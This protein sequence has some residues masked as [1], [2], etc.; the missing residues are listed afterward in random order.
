MSELYNQIVSQ[1]GSLENLI[2][3]I[4]GFRGYVDKAARRTADRMVRD[5]IADALSQRIAR[6]TQIETRL[7]DNGGLSYM[8]KTSRVK[9]K[10]QT[11]RDRVKAAAP[12]YS[13]WGEAQKVDSDALERIYSF[14]EALIRYA[15]QFDAA[16]DT[17]EQSATSSEG[18]D[19]A[20]TALD[21][22]TTEA[23]QAFSLREDVLTNLDKSLSS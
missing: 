7:L 10:L 2:A 4:P 9:M 18:V 11:Y 20:I 5:H 21:D 13:G 14:D 3:R 16:L 19:A 15:Q 6:M 8:S 22:L 12:G 23:N 1:R 17:L